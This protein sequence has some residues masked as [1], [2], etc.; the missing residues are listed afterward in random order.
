MITAEYP[1]YIWG[2]IGTA[3]W[4]MAQGYLMAG[5]DVSVITLAKSNK[6]NNQKNE[7][8]IDEGIKVYTILIDSFNSDLKNQHIVYSSKRS[9]NALDDMWESIK[10]YVD[11][12]LFSQSDIIILHNEELLGLALYLK[13]KL[14]VKLLYFCHGLHKFEHPDNYELH[15]IQSS[16]VNFS[17]AVVAIE[18]HLNTVNKI[19]PDTICLPIRLP[20]SILCQQSSMSLQ[21]PKKTRDNLLLVAAGRA[22][23]QKGFDIL[24]EAYSFVSKKPINLEINIYLG[25]GSSDYLE[26]CKRKCKQLEMS[27]EK[28]FKPWQSWKILQNIISE[29]DG[30]V[31]PSRFEPFGLIAA[32]AIAMETPIIV[33]E[34]GGLKEL[35]GYGK[36]GYLVK[37]NNRN[38]PCPQELANTIE[39]FY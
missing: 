7:L 9:A 33:S 5:Y 38:G 30:L 3:V 1:P 39:K 25:H 21:K 22:V 36:Y 19:F 20:L 23:R 29:A 18:S 8:I 37:S 31:V 13:Q 17:D 27:Y 35:A 32:E 24:L 16:A 28:I 12:N 15:S 34:V 11:F 14:Q 6:Q 2:G 10:Q 26:M 4:L